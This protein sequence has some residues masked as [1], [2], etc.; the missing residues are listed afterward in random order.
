MTMTNS[1]PDACSRARE[2]A[3]LSIIDGGGDLPREADAHLGA[4]PDCRAEVA[5]IAEVHDLLA[6][7]LGSARRDVADPTSQDID[8]ILLAVREEPPAA[9][10]LR[11]FRRSVMRMVWLTLLILSFLAIGGLAWALV[12]YL[13]HLHGG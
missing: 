9:R 3:R 10:L 2:S 1:E 4:C 11:R 6:R 12:V 5:R 13:R 8:R 7:A